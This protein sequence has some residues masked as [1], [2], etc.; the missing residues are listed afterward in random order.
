MKKPLLF[1]INL[2]PLNFGSTMYNC[3]ENIINMFYMS[4]LNNH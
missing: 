2:N 3:I 1:Y 4:N